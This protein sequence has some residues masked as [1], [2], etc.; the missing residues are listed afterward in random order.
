MTYKVGNYKY[1]SQKDYEKLL[2]KVGLIF[3]ICLYPLNILK[4]NM[5]ILIFYITLIIDVL[6]IIHLS[7]RLMHSKKIIK[8]VLN[9]Y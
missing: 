7:L 4:N 6:M 8:Y 3:I 1:K 2:I 9:E 5:N